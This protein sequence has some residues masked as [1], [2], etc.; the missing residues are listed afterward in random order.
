MSLIETLLVVAVITG[1]L[2]IF[3]VIAAVISDVLW[4]A[5][6]VWRHRRRCNRYR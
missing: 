3:F 6:A 4:P 2:G 5:L 1:G